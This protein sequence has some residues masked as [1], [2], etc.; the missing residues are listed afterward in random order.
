MKLKEFLKIADALTNATTVGEAIRVFLGTGMSE[1]HFQQ[2][3][4]DLNQ[5]YPAI[6]PSTII[7]VAMEEV[8]DVDDGI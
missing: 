1:A 7:K 2:L 4:A 3:V 6:S 5:N 8:D